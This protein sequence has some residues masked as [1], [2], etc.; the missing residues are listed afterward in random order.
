MNFEQLRTSTKC[1]NVMQKATKSQPFDNV[2][3]F[4]DKSFLT[5]IQANIKHTMYITT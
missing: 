4:F 1:T 2:E 5:T 3:V